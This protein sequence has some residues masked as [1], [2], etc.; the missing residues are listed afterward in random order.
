MLCPCV[1][2]HRRHPLQVRGIHGP[3]EN[4]RS[5][6]TKHHSFL[7]FPYVC[8]EP[9]LAKCSFLYINGAKSAVFCTDGH[10]R[11]LKVDPAKN[12]SSL[13]WVLS[14][15]C[16]SRACLGK[17]INFSIKWHRKRDK[18]VIYIRTSQACRCCRS[19][20]RCPDPCQSSR[21]GTAA[22]HRSCVSWPPRCRGSSARRRRTCSAQY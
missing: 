9:V 17:M 7:N 2:N 20:R 22:S 8:P 13:A 16:L 4:L 11:V 19:R 3:V 18:C 21:A 12:A 5:T 14:L 6:C 10:W 15:Q 1:G